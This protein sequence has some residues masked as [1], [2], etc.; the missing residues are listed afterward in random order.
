MNFWGHSISSQDVVVSHRVPGVSFAG[1]RATK[2]L[3]QVK[4]AK[5]I[6]LFHMELFIQIAVY[7]KL[8]LLT[9]QISRN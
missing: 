4:N 9:P 3:F 6:S 8:L 2:V 7:I 1:G 5:L